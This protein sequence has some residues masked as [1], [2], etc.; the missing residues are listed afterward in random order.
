MKKHLLHILFFIAL[1]PAVAQRE[2]TVWVRSEAYYYH[3]WYDRCQWYLNDP[4]L[5]LGEPEYFAAWPL[6]M[7]AGH[8][9]AVSI[10]TPRRM[11][12]RGVAVMTMAHPGYYT[13]ISN[14]KMPEIVTLYSA[15]S[16]DSADIRASAR[17]DTASPRLMLLPQT[18]DYALS[19]NTTGCLQYAIYEAYFDHPALVDSLFYISGSFNSNILTHIGTPPQYE[20]EPTVYGT[21][22]NG[23]V[24]N[25]CDSCLEGTSFYL[26]DSDTSDWSLFNEGVDHAG[27]FLAIPASLYLSALTADTLMGNAAG[28]G[29]YLSGMPVVITATPSAYCRFDH[30][31]DGSTDNPRVMYL[32][33]DTVVVAHF[34]N[35]SS[36]Y[37][38]VLVNNPE[39]GSATGTGLYPYGETIVI[40]AS[41]T[42]GYTFTEWADGDTNNPR[43][44]T[45]VSDT[46]FTAIF[47]PVLS[48]ETDIVPNNKCIIA[49]NPTQGVV[50]VSMSIYDTY[51][52]TI[53][54]DAGR[55][56]VNRTFSGNS[57]SLDISH[58]PSGNYIVAVMNSST[59]H[60]SV[61][62]KF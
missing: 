23:Y 1:L 56:R 20:N 5:I 57:V 46:V 52:V 42:N 41:P 58:L 33:Q 40:E 30:W 49:P 17:W 9:L 29:V 16:G 62:I 32:Y 4:G 31:S 11:A 10:T 45:P 34:I 43:S 25:R 36:N 47:D 15:L 22:E 55:C 6:N 28:S 26:K 21:V 12:L 18:H 50:K 35:D 14:D 3:D 38:R 2:D 60:A 44:V 13:T 7:T 51:T 19:G 61:L 8:E 37:V 54:D 59:H 53:Y 27:P 48:I 39:W 24:P